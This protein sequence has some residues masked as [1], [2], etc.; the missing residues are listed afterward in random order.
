[1]L[2]TNNVTKHFNNQTTALNG[3]SLCLPS[4]GLVFIVG[5]SGCGKSTLL[6]IFGGLDSPTSGEI[7]FCGRIIDLKNSKEA[8]EYRQNHIGFVFQS[9]NL[10]ENETALQNVNLAAELS[11]KSENDSISA[12]ER[13]R[14][15]GYE[16]RKTGDLSGGEKQRIAIARAIVKQPEIIL[17]DEPTGNLD[18]KNA[19]DIFT[20]LKEIS[21]NRLVVVV[22]HDE[23]SAGKFGDRIIRMCDGR[24]ISDNGDETNN[25]DTTIVAA[26]EV[27]K[28][29]LPLK[30]ILRRG[31]ATLKHKKLRTIITCLTLFL[32]VA[33]L[34]LGQMLASTTSEKS[35][36]RGLGKNNISDIILYQD[37]GISQTATPSGSLPQNL[38]ISQKAKDY[39]SGYSSTHVYYELSNEYYCIATGV[40]DVKSNGYSMYD[41]ALQTL[42]EGSFYL[43]DYEVDKEY[44]LH[45]ENA[46][47]D[48]TPYIGKKYTLSSS[49]W[50]YTGTL[51]GVIKTDY[52]KY[53]SWDD[54]HDVYKIREN[55]SAADTQLFSVMDVFFRMRYCKENLLVNAKKY[56]IFND[57]VYN[58]DG[59]SYYF[60]NY[61]LVYSSKK[62]SGELSSEFH[63]SENSAFGYIDGDGILQNEYD[64]DSGEAV[65]SGYAYLLLFGENYSENGTHIGEKVKLGLSRYGET[66]PLLEKEFTIVGVET[67]L[68]GK[69]ENDNAK[70]ICN[71]ADSYDFKKYAW[72]DSSFVGINLSGKPVS[73]NSMFFKQLRNCYDVAIFCPI[74][75][76]V[77]AT[78][79][80]FK[81]TGIIFTV[82]ATAM[83]VVSVLLVINMLAVMISDKSR[84]IGILRAI[85]VKSRD[86]TIIY[87]VKIIVIALITF[88]MAGLCGIAEVVFIMNTFKVAGGFK[89]PFIWFEPLTYILW[90]AT[91]LIIPVCMAFIPLNKIKRLKPIEAIKSE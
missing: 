77:Y 38:P 47:S 8:D 26:Q 28:R 17:A 57:N 62:N 73:E 72:Y 32:S 59:K 67:N 68:Y 50:S 81:T 49:T 85:G 53:Y 7:S 65:I 35:L 60:D 22:T 45:D 64:F 42:D 5:K 15:R 40:G 61:N 1:M 37:I 48:Y 90:V 63:I 14:L 83:L 84:E 29:G 18:S 9:Y 43:T 74:S 44:N 58:F 27:K 23:E 88:I 55:I 6:N 80:T 12:I 69:I 4:K 11:G 24:I 91:T 13:V 36:A 86:I 20:L 2:T 75:A 19:E 33:V 16:K 30:E 25:S 56:A 78:E 34:V 39:I 71:A 51:A 54:I 41:G 89:V 10:L 76:D 31:F 46:L 21:A 87:L 52:R 3:I 79:G 82:I 66:L 70:I